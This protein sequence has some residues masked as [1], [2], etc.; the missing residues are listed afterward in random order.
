MYHGEFREVL[1]YPYFNVSKSEDLAYH[2]EYGSVYGGV[3]ACAPQRSPELRDCAS[4]SSFGGR[5]G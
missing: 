2:T 5:G 4:A 3:R 1:D